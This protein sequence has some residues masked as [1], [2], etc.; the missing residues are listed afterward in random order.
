MNSNI[1][2]FLAVSQSDIAARASRG[3]PEGP[4]L[5]V[6]VSIVAL[7]NPKISSARPSTCS[8][9]LSIAAAMPPNAHPPARSQVVTW[10]TRRGDRVSHATS[11]SSAAAAIATTLYAGSTSGDGRSQASGTNAEPISAASTNHA[12]WRPGDGIWN[13][14][15]W[16]GASAKRDMLVLRV[17]AGVRLFSEESSDGGRAEKSATITSYFYGEDLRGESGS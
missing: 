8:E 16:C 17:T 4:G 13:V 7:Q 3:L 10:P 12:A 5:M 1:G 9:R 11:A 15:G 14:T 6:A 2:P